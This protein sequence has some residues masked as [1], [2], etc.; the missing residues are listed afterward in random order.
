[1]D[2][3]CRSISTCMQKRIMQ[4]NWLGLHS[5]VYMLT[6]IKEESTGPSYMRKFINMHCNSKTL[7]KDAKK[8]LFTDSKNKI[9]D[10]N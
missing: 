5:G 4:Q 1:M 3:A 7:F 6:L 2:W 10:L 9:V 8:P